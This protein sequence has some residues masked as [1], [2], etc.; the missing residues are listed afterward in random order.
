ML[1]ITGYADRYS[2]APGESIAFKVSSTSS[3]DYEVRLV[4]VICGDPNPAGPGIR[5]QPVEAAFAGRYPSRVQPIHNGSWARVAGTAPLDALDSFTVTAAIWPTLP[6]LAR[7][8]GLVSR[9]DDATGAG[10]TLEIDDAGSLAATL[11]DGTGTVVLG[12]GKPLRARAWYRVF[13]SY[14]ADAG[15][16]R[17]GQR[18]VAPAMTVDDSGTATATAAFEGSCTGS[19]DLAFAARAGSP[20]GDRYNGKFEA[21]RI[22]AAALDPETA[23]RAAGDDPAE[24]GERLVAAWDFSREMSSARILDTGP[25]AMHGETVNLPT[26][27]MKGS[28]WTG[29]EMCWRHAPSQYGAIHFHDDDLYDCGWDTDFTFDVPEDFRSGVYAVRLRAGGDEDMIPF[30]VRAAPGR[31]QSDACVLIPVFTYT[32]YANFAR[33]NVDDAYRDRVA[34]WGARPWTPDEHP[35]YGISTYNSHSDGSGVAYS[36]RLRPILNQR[37]GFCAYADPL[38]GSCLRHFPADTHL[39]AWLDALGHDFDVVTDEDLD[40]DGVAA[41]KQYKVVMTGS[42]PEYHTP[43]S[44]DAL[45]EYTE[46]GGRLMYLGGNGFY[47]RVAV[48]P[49]LPG[50]GRDP[51]RRGR[52]PRLG[53]GARGVL[54]RLRRRLWRAVAKQRPRAPAPSRGGF[55]RPGRFSRHRLPAA[56]RLPRPSRRLDLRGHRRRAARRLRPERRRGGRLRARL[57]GPQPRISAPCPRA[58]PLGAAGRHLHAGTGGDPEPL[59]QPSRPPGRGTHPLRDRVLRDSQRRRGVLGRLDHL[60][61]KPSPQRLRQQHIAHARQRVATVPRRLSGG[62]ALTRASVSVTLGM[63]ILPVAVASGGTEGRRIR[64]PTAP[65]GRISRPFS[66]G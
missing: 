22:V 39:L 25:H 43:G 28:S 48:N 7:R 49:E 55:H 12:T 18:P 63:D 10:F 34:R 54:Q 36:S 11:S 45:T 59:R 46:G 1:P 15:E 24:I 2:V 26:R 19:G 31:A 65:F 5:E 51:P 56:A 21:P 57:A 8:Q 60:L 41:I 47:W 40:A 64:L 9:V 17:V 35:E 58:R 61:R 16:V 44:L 62:S 4:R 6:D 23:F 29:E 53:G 3:E 37:S 14:D 52:N 32:V 27:A 50:A 66:K 38:G 20:P 42:H 30:F 33:G 13:L